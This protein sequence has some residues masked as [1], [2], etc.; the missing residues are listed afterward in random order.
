MSEKYLDT[1]EESEAQFCEDCGKEMEIL[2]EFGGQKYTKCVNP[3]CPAK[4]DGDAKELAEELCWSEE[5]RERLEA[6]DKYFT[7]RIRFLEELVERL[8]KNKDV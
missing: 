8:E 3:C 6:R 7:D 4:F 2:D 5:I 1:P